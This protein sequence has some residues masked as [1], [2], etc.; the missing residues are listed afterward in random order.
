MAA[1]I[2][3]AA[4]GSAAIFARRIERICG[5]PLLLRPQEAR[6]LLQRALRGGETDALQ[7]ASAEMLQALQRER[8]M[9]AALGGHEGVNLI[10]DDGF[11]RAQQLGAR[12]R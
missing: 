1:G 5:E 7:A 6:N 2:R 9:R 12:W 8:Q 11:D 3:L 4:S 10:D